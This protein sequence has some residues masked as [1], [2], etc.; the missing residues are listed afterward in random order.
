M[1]PN[2]PVISEICAT[3]CRVTY[4]APEI[5]VGGPPVI[6]YF[7]EART[8]D[9]PWIRVNNIPITGTKVRVRNL[10]CDIRYEFRVR[11]INDNGC[12]E[13]STPSAAVVPFT[14]NRPSQ[15]GRPVA[16]ASGSSVSLTWFMWGGDS[17][18]EHF[19]YVIRCREAKTKRTILY[20]STEGKAGTTIH[21]R[22]TNDMLK[23]ETQYEFAVAACNEAGLGSFSTYSDCVKTL[24]GRLYNMCQ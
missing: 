5:Q 16:T 6:G 18:T 13:Y 21:H 17:E 12:G 9:G 22:L 4:Q 19:R 14:E 3:S 15:P 10:Y 2:T 8:L 1:P 23:P 20:A 24:S 11:A 7:L